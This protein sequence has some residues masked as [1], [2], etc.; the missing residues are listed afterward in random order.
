M[1]SNDFDKTSERVDIEDAGNVIHDVTEN[2][3]FASKTQDF[4]PNSEEKKQPSKRTLREEYLLEK[5]EIKFTVGDLEQI[6]LKLGLSQRKICQ[7][8]LV[9]PS[10][11]TRWIQSSDG[12]PPHVYQALRWL[13]QLKDQNPRYLASPQLDSKMDRI[14][15]TLHNKIKSLEEEMASLQREIELGRTFSL[16]SQ[17]LPP[18]IEKSEE[19]IDSKWVYFIILTIGIVIGFVG[20]IIAK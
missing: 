15:Q 18:F 1:S 11:W 7:L 13:I 3:E 4:L 9:D 8:L 14:K 16:H 12:A 19:K 17:S 2:P 10:A 6:R 5:E 20:H